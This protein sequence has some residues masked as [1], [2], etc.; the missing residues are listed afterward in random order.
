MHDL[1]LTCEWRCS[2]ETRTK[3]SGLHANNVQWKT[4]FVP[5]YY[6]PFNEKMTG[7]EMSQSGQKDR[8]KYKNPVKSV[9]G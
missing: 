8:D 2:G 6:K 4:N 9:C 3:L 7:K 5:Q 1:Q